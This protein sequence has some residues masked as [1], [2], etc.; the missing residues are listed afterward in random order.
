[1]KF[2]DL[3]KT[4]GEKGREDTQGCWQHIV[5]GWLNNCS[6]LDVGAGLN[7]SKERMSVRGINVTTLDPGPG[8]P[9]D[10]NADI[11]TVPDKSYD[12][13]TLFDV[14]E[15]I[16]DGGEF[17]YNLKRVAKKWI[18]MTTPNVDHTGGT[19]EYHFHEFDP[20]EFILC[21]ES[22][23]LKFRHGWMMFP[24]GP[25]N[26]REASLQ[27]FLDR[28]FCYNFCVIFELAEKPKI[29]TA[30]QNVYTYFD[31]DPKLDDRSHT[32]E[33]WKKTWRDSGWNP[34][35][36]G[37]A[38]AEKHPEY[39]SFMAHI[40]TLPSVNPWGYEESCYLRWLAMDLVGGLHVDGD[41]LN[42][43]L[44]PPLKFDINMV[45]DPQRV[46]C[47]V[48][49]V[50][51]AGIQNLITKFKPSQGIQVNGKLHCSDMIAFQASNIA[52]YEMCFEFGTP[53]S[54]SAPL[55]HFASGALAKNGFSKDK[56]LDAFNTL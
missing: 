43:D 55:V 9:V 2:I 20:Q 44:I 29:E 35:V 28:K 31:Q 38:D 26:I 1:M 51:G 45:L 23:G 42:I 56:M 50:K 36:L 6:L 49:V 5:A 25:P 18:V 24:D 15:H 46:P 14:I 54:K 4:P 16:E 30:Q 48:W 13:V 12:A 39:E 37:R 32:L 22:M 3:A 47:A 19:H 7:G 27:E 34:V 17:I 33:L 21:M 10:I 41:V 52:T 40:K 11:S 8:L 53:E